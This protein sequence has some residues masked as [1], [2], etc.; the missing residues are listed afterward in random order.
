LYTYNDVFKHSFFV[1]KDD[2]LWLVWQLFK[3]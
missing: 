1:T 2:L 3:P